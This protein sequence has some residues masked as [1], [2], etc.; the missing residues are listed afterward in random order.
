MECEEDTVIEP[1]GVQEQ[2]KEGERERERTHTRK[3]VRKKNSE[4]S[5]AC[6]IKMML[7]AI[8]RS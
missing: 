5:K 1:S 8:Q 6:S 3:H 4:E 2:R 7:T